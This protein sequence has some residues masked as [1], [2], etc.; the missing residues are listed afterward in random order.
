MQAKLCFPCFSLTMRK[1]KYKK[2]LRNTIGQIISSKI[3]CNDTWDVKVESLKNHCY[4][5]GYLGISS[6]T[7]SPWK[8]V[9]ELLEENETIRKILCCRANEKLQRSI[10][11]LHRWNEQGN[12]LLVITTRLKR[13]ITKGWNKSKQNAE[14]E[15]LRWKTS[16]QISA[17]LYPAF[18]SWVWSFEKHSFYLKSNLKETYLPV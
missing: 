9:W 6:I 10:R 2:C 13:P 16:V 7:S 17:D 11:L 3:M 8:L 4:Q 1:S 5:A 12:K 18:L 15:L 14:G